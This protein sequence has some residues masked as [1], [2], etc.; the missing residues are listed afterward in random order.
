MY[1]IV[2]T[3]VYD[4]G[5]MWI[6]ADEGEG[7]LEADRLA[8]SKFED[9]HHEDGHHKYELRKFNPP[10]PSDDDISWVHDWQDECEL[11]YTGNCHD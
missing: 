10:K 11:I 3:A 6:G 8:S 5:V 2:K 9:G 7:R 4:H 1:I